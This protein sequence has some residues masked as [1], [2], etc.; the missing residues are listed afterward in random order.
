MA[1]PMADRLDGFREPWNENL[2]TQK[3]EVAAQ[4]AQAAAIHDQIYGDTVSRRSKQ[5]PAEGP[6]RNEQSREEQRQVREANEAAAIERAN[7]IMAVNREL[8]DRRTTRLNEIAD[9]LDQQEDREMEDF[10]GDN[11]VPKD[12]AEEEARRQEEADRKARETE[13]AAERE[14]REAEAERARLAKEDAQAEAAERR[15]AEAAARAAQEQGAAPAPAATPPAERRHK[16]KVNGREIELTDA[17]LIARASKV[18]AADEYLARAADL[19]RQAAARLQTPPATGTTSSP[20]APSAQDAPPS[21]DDDP[22]ED[23]L[24]S[25]LQGDADAIAKLAQRLKRPAAPQ[26][27]AEQLLRQVDERMTFRSAVDW[28]NREYADVR[29]DADLWEIAKREDTRLAGSEPALP[30]QERLRRVGEHVR[31]FVA[32]LKGTSSTAPAAQATPASPP[33]NPR[34]ARKAS[35]APVPVA[36]GRQSAPEEDEGPEDTASVID[37]MAKARNQQGAIRKQGYGSR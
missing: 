26:V 30:P 33:V 14:E 3:R 18:E 4:N 7:S 23:T 5:T 22:V 25:A 11:I 6:N 8:N 16:I 13:E 20:V 17:E 29:N 2:P 28:F 12:P 21:G 35:V 10:D 36:G 31:G 34:L 9:R 19:Q 37:Q 32:R 1:S 27:N 24:T 15:Q